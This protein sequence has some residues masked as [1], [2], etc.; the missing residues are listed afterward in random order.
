MHLQNSETDGFINQQN[1]WF[2]GIDFGPLQEE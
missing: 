1:D 2:T